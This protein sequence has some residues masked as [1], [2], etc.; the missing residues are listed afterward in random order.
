ML[1]Q[2]GTEGR[3]HVTSKYGPVKAMVSI[4]IVIFFWCGHRVGMVLFIMR[5]WLIWAAHFQIRALYFTTLSSLRLVKQIM[6]LIAISLN[7]ISAEVDDLN[8]SFDEYGKEKC[9]D[10]SV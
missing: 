3:K 4:T 10:L 6:Q 5:F 1:I 2:S 8:H 9:Q 7:F